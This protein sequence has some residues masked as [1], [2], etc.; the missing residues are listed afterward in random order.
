MY[1]RSAMET[2]KWR[3]WSLPIDSGED[4]GEGENE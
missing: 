4:N 3:K 2:Q 1:S